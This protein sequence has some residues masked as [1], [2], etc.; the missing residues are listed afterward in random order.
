VGGYKVQS[1]V[2]ELVPE[3][4]LDPG[5]I[6]SPND[7]YVWEFRIRFFKPDAE[8]GGAQFY[9]RQ[10]NHQCRNPLGIFDVFLA[11]CGAG[12]PTDPVSFPETIEIEELG[13]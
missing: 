5:Y 7:C 10:R 11:D 3:N 9:Y 13:I 1:A 12:D 6:A 2:L 8:V 4:Y